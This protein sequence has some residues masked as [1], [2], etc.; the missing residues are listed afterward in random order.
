MLDFQVL[1]VGWM[2]GSAWVHI[3]C[4]TRDFYI[5]KDGIS[6]VFGFCVSNF[7]PTTDMYHSH[8][9]MP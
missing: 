6:L 4:F 3:V 9:P 2:D 7:S 5:M 1:C 8:L